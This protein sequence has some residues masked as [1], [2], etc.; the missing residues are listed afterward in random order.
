[1]ALGGYRRSNVVVCAYVAI[2]IFGHNRTALVRHVYLALGGVAG[3]FCV[4]AERVFLAESS[5]T[6]AS[7]LGGD[8]S[9]RRVFI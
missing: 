8:I 2:P 3:S 5:H 6:A 9:N 7:D 4:F 1:M